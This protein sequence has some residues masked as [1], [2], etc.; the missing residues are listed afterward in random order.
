M[1]NGRRLNIPSYCVQVGDVITIRK[2]SQT[3]PLFINR[4][5]AAAE[6]KLPAWL[7]MQEGRV[8]GHGQ[9]GALGRRDRSSVLRGGY[10]PVLQPLNEC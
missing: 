7:E 3:S 1:V 8:R 4:V 6:S 10:H 9:E 2:E 5:E